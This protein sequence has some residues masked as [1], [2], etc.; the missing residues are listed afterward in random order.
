MST[1][2]KATIR[3]RYKGRGN[4]WVKVPNNS[5]VFQT[6]VSSLSNVDASEYLSHIDREGFA[7]IRFSKPSGNQQEPLVTYEVRYRGSKFD[8]PDNFITI[9]DSLA[10]DLPL[11]GNTPVKL[12]LETDPSVRKMKD[13]IPHLKKK[14]NEYVALNKEEK[15]DIQ[16][17][18]KTIEVAALSKPTTQELGQWKTF[19][20]EEG[21]LDYSF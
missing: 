19:L 5:V 13:D 14:Q 20:L 18:I 8:H 2:F 12:Q 21:L 1:N 4:C 15:V 11:L 3:N 9:A 7:W 10:K 6:V 16:D 17:R